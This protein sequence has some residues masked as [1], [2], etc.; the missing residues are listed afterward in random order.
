MECR[1]FGV[2]IPATES[3]K[4]SNTP[5]NFGSSTDDLS[6]IKRAKKRT[7]MLI[8]VDTEYMDCRFIQPT[9]NHSEIFFSVADY[10]LG[11][12]R[13]NISTPQYY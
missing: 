11:T 4:M 2:R 13:C 1:V 12:R 8:G 3:L 10:A 9:S 7:K 6:F 5:K